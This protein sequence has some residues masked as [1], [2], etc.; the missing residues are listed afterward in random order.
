[1]PSLTVSP[2]SG[3]GFQEVGSS[4]GAASGAGISVLSP[5]AGINLGSGGLIILALVGLVGVIFISR[6]L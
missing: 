3:T 4:N 6:E 5:G 1:M 2:S